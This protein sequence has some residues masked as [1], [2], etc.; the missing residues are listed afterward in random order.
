MMPPKQMLPILRG[1]RKQLRRAKHGTRSPIYE[2]WRA[3]LVRAHEAGRITDEGFAWLSI[4]EHVFAKS[5]GLP[6]RKGQTVWFG[7]GYVWRG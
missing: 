4:V 1:I 7:N 3:Q 5:W 2:K 6:L